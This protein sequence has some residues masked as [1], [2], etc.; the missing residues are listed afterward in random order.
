[1][2]ITHTP[3]SR[4]LFCIP[5][6]R[7]CLVSGGIRYETSPDKWRYDQARWD[8]KG[9]PPHTGRQ[10]DCFCEVLLYA[11]QLMFTPLRAGE[12]LFCTVELD[13]LV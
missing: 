2:R 10:S 13:Q 8:K 11:A 5:I 12:S 6:I 9:L 7:Y 1:M 4:S 3:V